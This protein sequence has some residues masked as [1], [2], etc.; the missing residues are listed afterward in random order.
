MNKFSRVLYFET[1]VPPYDTSLTAYLLNPYFL[2]SLI[3]VHCRQLNVKT[4]SMYHY[5]H[6]HLVFFT[7]KKCMKIY[8]RSHKLGLGN[9]FCQ[10]CRWVIQ[11][12]LFIQSLNYNQTTNLI[13]TTHISFPTL[14]EWL[15]ISIIVN[16]FVWCNH[17]YG[18]YHLYDYVVDVNQYNFTLFNNFYKRLTDLFLLSLIKLFSSYCV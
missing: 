3:L 1:E 16:L 17:L 15:K 12:P 8:L 10:N 18:L 2:L 11:K 13:I 7:F 9:L 6:R 4:S 5:F 14:I